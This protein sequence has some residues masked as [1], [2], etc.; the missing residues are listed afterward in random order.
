MGSVSASV[1]RSTV[2]ILI[3]D[4][5]PRQK[6]IGTQ[7]FLDKAFGEVPTRPLQPRVI[8]LARLLSQ[9]PLTNIAIL[10]EVSTNLPITNC[11]QDR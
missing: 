11:L 5:L 3:Q 4:L 10:V 1:S 2:L 6:R 7:L 8:G 9:L